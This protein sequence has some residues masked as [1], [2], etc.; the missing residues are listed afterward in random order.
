MPPEEVFENKREPILRNRKDA[1]TVNVV[2]ERHVQPA[3][4]P[5]PQNG[6]SPISALDFESKS[7]FCQ[8]E[9][10]FKVEAAD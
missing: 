1:A 10:C 5:L 6:Q 9:R 4:A 7:S 3:V 8:R 2:C